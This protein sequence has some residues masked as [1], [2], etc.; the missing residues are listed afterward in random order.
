MEIRLAA[1]GILREVEARGRSNGG[2]LRGSGRFPGV[3]QAVTSSRSCAFRRG[4][5]INA[6]GICTMAV[7]AAMAFPGDRSRAGDGIL[8]TPC[9][10]AEPGMAAPPPAGRGMARRTRAARSGQRLAPPV[11]RV[12]PVRPEGHR[13]ALPVHLQEGGA[14]RA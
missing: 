9:H 14:V 6:K 10:S 3:T 11:T 8:G 4:R 1:I 12:R 7:M 2:A 5:G 13:G